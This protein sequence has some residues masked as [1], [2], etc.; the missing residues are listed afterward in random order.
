MKVRLEYENFV[1]EIEHATREE[2]AS[3]LPVAWQTLW[4]AAHPEEM[5]NFLA[6]ARR[7]LAD[8]Q[9]QRPVA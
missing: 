2:I 7:A 1:A 6:V 5:E 9:A 4:G 3:A 8:V